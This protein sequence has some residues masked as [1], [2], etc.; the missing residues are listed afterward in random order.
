MSKKITRHILTVVLTCIFG[1]MPAYADI[2]PQGSPPAAAE[3]TTDA[4]PA[5]LKR[6]AIINSYNE[7]T[8]WPRLFINSIISEMAL[9]KDFEP[10]KVAHLNNSL[11]CNKEEYIALETRLFDFFKNSKP[12]YLIVIGNFAFTLR[13]QYKAHWGNLPILLLSQNNKYADLEYYFTVTTNSDTHIPPKMYAMEDLQEDYNFTSL[14]TRNKYRE[15]I[16]LMVQM[17]PDMKKLIFM[18]IGIY[19]NQHLSFLIREY[20]GLKYPDMEYEWVLAEED[21]SMVPYLNNTDPNVGLLLSNWTYASTGLSGEILFRSGDSYLIKG[22][23]RPV[24]GLR[25]SYFNYGIIGGYFCD[26]N[27]FNS[28]VLEGLSELISD[29]D[30]SQIPFRE[31]AYAPYIDF[32]KMEKLEIDESRCPEGTIF[33][34]R[35]ENKW[36]TYRGYVYAGVITLLVIIFALIIYIVTRKRPIIRRDYDNLVNSMPLGFMQVLMVLDKDGTIKKIEYSERNRHLREIIE[37]YNLRD[38]IKDDE[39]TG[40]QETIDIIRT[41]YKTKAVTVKVPDSDTY[42]EFIICPDKHSNDTY[43]FANIFV[44]DVSDKMRI[45]NVLRE[46]AKKRSRQTI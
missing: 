28:M 46:T 7:N 33:I 3:K 4:K 22:A 44:I 34:N 42:F 30:M 2:P 32:E 13:D 18:G 38:A 14:I 5:K 29:K 39:K 45:E 26:V 24:F 40:W 9:H 23:R 10:V 31:P 15:T 25:Y 21:G 12:D 17:Y 16:D 35:K 27:E 8:P 41:D 11:I 20:L 37:D 19:A 6:L 36:E 1:C 43:F